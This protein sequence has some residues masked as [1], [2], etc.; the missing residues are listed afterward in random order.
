[1]LFV[2]PWKLEAKAAS[3]SA[4]LRLWACAVPG[5]NKMSARAATIPATTTAPI[6]HNGYRLIV[7][8]VAI[9]AFPP[10]QKESSYALL[11]PVS[12]EE[13][14]LLLLARQDSR[15]LE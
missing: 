1:M 6:T 2:F 3:S 9:K 12:L 8:V 11:S 10:H 4:S 13:G 15:N 7:V 5:V 14:V